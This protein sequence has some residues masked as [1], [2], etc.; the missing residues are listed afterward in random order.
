M[1]DGNHETQPVS[2]EKNA[3]W[4]PVV[5]ERIAA[6]LVH[7]LGKWPDG[8]VKALALGVSRVLLLILDG[9]L[10]PANLTVLAFGVVRVLVD[11]EANEP[12]SQQAS[13]RRGLLDLYALA[14][15]GL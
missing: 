13:V 12:N 14:R 8:R 6:D 7:E 10:T 3:E 9:G 1:S 11:V 2:T 5:A 15:S 4:D